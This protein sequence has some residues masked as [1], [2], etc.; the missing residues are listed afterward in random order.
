MFTSY[1]HDR[2]WFT[3]HPSLHQYQR[4]PF[5][6]EWPD[7]L[8]PPQAVVTVHLINPHCTVRVLGVP[9]EPR[10]AEVL[11]TDPTHAVLPVPP[12]RPV[13][14]AQPVAPRAWRV[15]QSALVELV[16]AGKRRHLRCR[17]RTVHPTRI[18]VELRAV[19]VRFWVAPDDLH[20][21]PAARVE[22]AG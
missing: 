20:P 4:A 21:D 11:D 6:Y 5:A 2:Q 17:I 10:L 22:L 1:K 18:E 8:V 15:D 3:L 12:A 9:H 7:L 14:P 13:L 16:H 19:S